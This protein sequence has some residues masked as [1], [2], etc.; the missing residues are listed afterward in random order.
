MTEGIYEEF[1]KLAGKVLEM[2]SRLKKSTVT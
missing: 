1:R 2:E